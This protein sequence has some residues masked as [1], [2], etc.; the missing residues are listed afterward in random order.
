ML[1]K[2]AGCGLV[3]SS[4]V[5]MRPVTRMEAA[6][7]VSE[8]TRALKRPSAPVFPPALMAG[9]Q[10]EFKAEIA[11]IEGRSAAGSYFKPLRN[12]SLGYVYQ[13]GQDSV[14][15]SK[16]KKSPGGEIDARQFAL[17]VNNDGVDYD[18]QH[19]LQLGFE[20]EIRWSDWGLLN[21]RPL[22]LG[23]SMEEDADFSLKTLQ[24]LAVLGLGPVE[25]SAGR[26][27]LWWGQGYNGTLVLTNNAKP[28]DMVRLTNPSPILLPWIFSSLGPFRFDFF[29][30]E[31]EKDRAVPDPYLGGLRLN[32][33]PRPWLEIGASRTLM[34]GG[35]GRPSVDFKDFMTI[36]GGTNLLGD[37]D[38]SNQLAALDARIKIPLLNGL[39]VYGEWG[40]EDQ[41]N[42]L[43]FISNKAYMVGI[44][45][46]CL[47]PNGWFGARFELAD[48]SHI[49]GNS[50]PW[51]RHNVYES[52][53]TYEG[54]I[55][56]HHVGGAGEDW[57]AQIEAMLPGG[58]LLQLAYDYQ[59]RGVDHP[60][61]EKHQ[62]VLWRAIL[63][64][65][66]SLDVQ[67]SGGL[68]W[69]D[70]FNQVS[71]LDRTQSF[72]SLLLSGRF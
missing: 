36:L 32:F 63:P 55:L 18:E 39:D 37:E 21:W 60:V 4:L 34:F 22:L 69:I 12:P 14:T 20:S 49:D 68:D 47:D 35:K 9:L 41:S 1:D 51:Y 46:P 2:L 70:N 43:P 25:I 53:Y 31:L 64:V 40:G 50:S 29:I 67:A 66:Q 23:T 24:A 16:S 3:N 45:L 15:A 30:S 65:G 52:G 10:E 26:Q 5:G 56:G 72:A 61:E 13:H 48:L 28:L 17:T 57:F 62:K 42:G 38:T 33:K 59:K 54:R 44:Y 27:S 11:E 6:R 58:G 71:G 7:Q 19:N 8:A